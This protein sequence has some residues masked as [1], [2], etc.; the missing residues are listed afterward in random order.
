MTRTT[1]AIIFSPY[2]VH[3]EIHIIKR[4]LWDLNPKLFADKIEE[5]LRSGKLECNT[6]E[7]ALRF[8]QG[9]YPHISV[10]IS[11]D[12]RMHI[13]EIKTRRVS[14][15]EMLEVGAM[16]AEGPKKHVLKQRE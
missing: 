8:Y 14:T 12:L 16:E 4:A 13:V 11:P 9:L 7:E 6:L 15:Q 3:S 5:A 2:Q 10:P 1:Y